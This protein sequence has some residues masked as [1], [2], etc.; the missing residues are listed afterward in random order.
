MLAS[1]VHDSVD[2]AEVEFAGLRLE[3][4]PIDGSLDGVGMQCGH[5]LPHLRQ[6]ARPG[7]GVVNLAAENE[8]GLAINQQGVTTV[9][10]HES[11]RFGGERGKE[12]GREEKEKKGGSKLRGISRGA[13]THVDYLMQECNRIQ[14]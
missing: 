8:K 10:L 13:D 11:R 2:V 14:L 12:G 6:F 4:L 5:G 1:A 3:L 9:L 7:A